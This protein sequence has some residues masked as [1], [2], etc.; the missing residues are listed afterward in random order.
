VDGT[1]SLAI[2]PTD[3]REWADADDVENSEEVFANR[4]KV[5]EAA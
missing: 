3:V 4:E 5:V 1:L 2:T